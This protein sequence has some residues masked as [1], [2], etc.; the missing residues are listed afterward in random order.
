MTRIYP[1]YCLKKKWTEG[2]LSTYSGGSFHLH[3]GHLPI[4]CP[5]PTST[6]EAV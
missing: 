1:A 4:F 3:A 6:S 5:M 2:A